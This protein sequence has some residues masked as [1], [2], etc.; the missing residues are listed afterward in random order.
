MQVQPCC[1]PQ[2][3]SILTK[4][5]PETNLES[6]LSFCKT[7]FL[8][9][10][11]GRTA[12]WASFSPKH[13][14]SWYPNGHPQDQCEPARV[15]QRPPAR[16]GQ[17]ER[18][19]PPVVSGSPHGTGTSRSVA[20]MAT[21]SLDQK[22]YRTSPIS[23]PE[24]CFERGRTGPPCLYG[25]GSC[26]FRRVSGGTN[27]ALR[28]VRGANII[29]MPKN[30]HPAAG[31]FCMASASVAGPSVLGMEFPLKAADYMLVCSSSHSFCSGMVLGARPIPRVP[32]C[33]SLAALPAKPRQLS[34]ATPPCLLPNRAGFAT[35]G[36]ERRLPLNENCR[37]D[38]GL[39]RGNTQCAPH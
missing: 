3:K 4:P 16:L 36:N 21:T 33:S 24:G 13:F 17:A 28:T 37:D 25:G 35:Y 20:I 34:E 7:A 2:S 26:A 6:T 19:I 5:C 1:R 30:M 8:P 11:V 9:W 22:G 18:V 29:G 38:P 12:K 14:N 23:A 39:H 27:R 15:F 32:V 31:R 10:R